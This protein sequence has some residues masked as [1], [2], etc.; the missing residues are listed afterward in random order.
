[1]SI[2]VFNVKET[3]KDYNPQLYW[4]ERCIKYGHTGDADSLIYQYDQPQR[5]RAIDKALSRAKVKLGE[6]SRILD[7]GC[8]TGDIISLFISKGISNVTGID[9]SEEVIKSA[10]G[11]FAGNK[12][13]E[14]DVVGIETAKFPSN[15]FDLV[16]SINVLQHIVDDDTFLGVVANIIRMVRMG[17]YVL[18]MEFSPIKAKARRPEPCVVV[19]SRREYVDVFENNGCRL[20]CYFGLPRLG[21]RFL[22]SIFFK[23]AIGTLVRLI[24]KPVKRSLG[25]ANKP[26]SQLGE[27]SPQSAG[28]SPLDRIRKAVLTFFKPFDHLLVPFPSRYTDMPILIFQKVDK[29]E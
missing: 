18:I 6:D 29:S 11:R 19:R 24:P 21:V 23:K 17:G 28:K 9:L 2:N 16:T 10:K 12:N 4:N 3:M 27:P 14:L 1:M 13:V 5:V 20:V 7:V 8:G 15:M 25:T 22:R 26:A